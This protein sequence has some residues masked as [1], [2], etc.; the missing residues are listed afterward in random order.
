MPSPGNN[1]K[2]PLFNRLVLPLAVPALVLLAWQALSDRGFLRPSILPSPW[3]VAQ[4]LESLVA[5]GQLLNHLRV[6]LIRV[7]E[8]FGIGAGL[9]TLLGLAMGLSPFLNRALSLVTGLLRPIPT[10][11]WIPI[12]ILWM[13]I[14]EGSKVTVIAVGS[15]WPVL[16]NVIQGVRGIDPKYLEVARVLEKGWW[17]VLGRV[18]LPS[19]LPSLF[20]GLRVGLGIAWASVVGA[21]LIAASSGIGYMI[22]YAREVSQPDVMLVGI[23]SI[24][25]TGLLMDFLVVQLERR[26]LKWNQAGKENQA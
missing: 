16:L 10:I 15:F 18:V 21:E 12:L 20:T 17:E 6:S 23:V 9:G 3:A 24:G 25:L 5:S 11:A 2:T 26:L 19:A 4:T 7:F 14:D 1:R 8:G 13:G 22:M